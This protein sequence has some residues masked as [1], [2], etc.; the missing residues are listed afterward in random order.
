MKKARATANPAC[1]WGIATDPTTGGLYVT[2]IGNERVQKFSAS[3][4]F[5][6]AFGSHGSGNGQ[7]SWHRGGSRWA[8]PGP[9]TSPTAH[10]DRVSEWGGKSR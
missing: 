6:A 2:E 5:I 7:F 3:G 4:A 9:S 8:P 1:E 10:N